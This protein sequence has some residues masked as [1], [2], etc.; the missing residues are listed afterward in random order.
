MKSKTKDRRY[1]SASIEVVKGNGVSRIENGMQEEKMG[2][3]K[4]K[5]N[6]DWTA[7]EASTFTLLGV[8]YKTKKTNPERCGDY[9]ATPPKALE[10]LL[11]Q[12]EFENVWECAD[13]EGHLCRVLK[14]HG[15]LAKHSDIVYRGCGEVIDFLKYE[16]EWNGDIITNPPYRWALDFVLKALEIIPTGRKVAM[17]LRIQFLEGISRR[18]QL[19]EENPPKRVYIWS[20]RIVCAVNG[21]FDEVQSGA[22]MY[23]WFVWEKGFK[24]DPVIKWLDKVD[25]TKKTHPELFYSRE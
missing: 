14:R 15:I 19:F 25:N 11:Q 17:L 23:S 3:D 12:E 20:R 8:N 21:K 18:R 2:T 24:G 1:F 10:D 9:Y 5:N 13:G 16:G 4:E 6:R 7:N 22:I